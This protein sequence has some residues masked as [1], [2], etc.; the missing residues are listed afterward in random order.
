MDSFIWMENDGHMNFIRHDIANNPT[1]ILPLELGD[2]NNDGQVDMVT[3]G[4]HVYPPYDRMARIM[5]WTNNW[6]RIVQ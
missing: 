2:F 4:M 6:S 1:H 3:G 5:L